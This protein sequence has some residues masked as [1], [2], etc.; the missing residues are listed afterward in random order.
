MKSCSFLSN[1]CVWLSLHLSR[2]CPVSFQ[3]RNT[4]ALIAVDVLPGCC[5]C[6]PSCSVVE[7]ATC[8]AD[9]YMPRPFPMRPLSTCPSPDI[10]SQQQASTQPVLTHLDDALQKTESLDI[11]SST[12]VCCVKHVDRLADFLSLEQNDRVLRVNKSACAQL[13]QDLSH[14]LNLSPC[15]SPFIFKS[16]HWHSQLLVHPQSR[17]SFYPRLPFSILLKSTFT[18]TP[19]LTVHYFSLYTSL[20]M[21]SLPSASDLMCRN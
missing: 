18:S 9:A 2:L 17:D 7:L 10:P 4:W 5:Y 12:S 6:W 1:I 16:L 21:F 13:D 20:V 11:Y 14:S 15:T 3:V 19:P 8:S